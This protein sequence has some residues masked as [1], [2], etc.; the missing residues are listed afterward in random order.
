MSGLKANI[1]STTHPAGTAGRP[2]ANAGQSEPSIDDILASI[3]QIISDQN[4]QADH[5]AEK[6]AAE[7]A[8]KAP[9]GAKVE[10]IIGAVAA[11]H[12]N[13]TT[14]AANSA[15]GNPSELEELIQLIGS[16]PPVPHPTKQ[17]MWIDPKSKST[18][19]SKPV[20]GLTVKAA[21]AITQSSIQNPV[22]RPAPVTRNAAIELKSQPA[23]IVA[24]AKKENASLGAIK[25][26]VVLPSSL[27]KFGQNVGHPPGLNPSQ[28]VALRHEATS[29]PRLHPSVLPKTVIPQVIKEAIARPLAKTVAAS[30][31]ASPV[32]DTV[33]S[34]KSALDRLIARKAGMDAGL[35]SVVETPVQQF[36]AQQIPVQQI[37]A[38]KAVAPSATP[39]QAVQM[40]IAPTQPSGAPIANTAQKS[41]G[42]SPAMSSQA[43]NAAVVKSI[44]RLATSMFSDRKEE[45]DGMMA[46]IVRPML[47]DWL[48]DNLPSL[49]ERIV[50]EEI[51]RVSRGTHQ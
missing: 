14:N 50:R 31:K 44:E 2:V 28:P 33:V 16:T 7:V 9:V 48:E 43:V 34:N 30:S 12:W 27:S 24:P 13:D 38:P 51:E 23:I 40:P 29:E 25:P 46:G 36:Q 47:Q 15:S 3:R 19:N 26:A 20:V 6:A 1:A 39:Q 32:Q 22:Q 10:S 17:A 4:R 35:A 49:V 11:D 41:T 8:N 45:I 37:I 5:A 42:N 18:T 21:A